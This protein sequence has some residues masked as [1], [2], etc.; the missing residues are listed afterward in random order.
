MKTR[1]KNL[2]LGKEGIA[3]A[4]KVIPEEG[5]SNTMPNLTLEEYRSTAEKVR[6]SRAR[7]IDF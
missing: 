2:A 7:L 5:G 1:E 4:R 3:Y 6:E